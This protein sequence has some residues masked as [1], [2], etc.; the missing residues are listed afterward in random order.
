MLKVILASFWLFLF[1]G[2]AAAINNNSCWEND[3]ETEFIKDGD[4][5]RRICSWACSYGHG[6]WTGQWK[7]IV[8]NEKSVCTCRFCTWG[9]DK[10]F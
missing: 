10:E 1:A 7:T 2:T 4:H 5:A 6:K 9:L 3:A 8:Q